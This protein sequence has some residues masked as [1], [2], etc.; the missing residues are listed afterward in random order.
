LIDARSR[1]R[2]AVKFCGVPAFPKPL[3][4]TTVILEPDRPVEHDHDQASFGSYGV[5]HDIRR[6]VAHPRRARGRGVPFRKIDGREGDDGPWLAVFEDGE[7]RRR[8]TPNRPPVL[9]EDRD[10]HLDDV[11]PRLKRSRK[12]RGGGLLL[13]P[14][15]GGQDRESEEANEHTRRSSHL[16]VSSGWRGDST[17][18]SG[19]RTCR[20]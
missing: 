15:V 20:D 5:G 8:Q 9:V 1:D 17:S 14:P 13:R 2:S 3:E 11:N 6:D 19:E 12:L 4:K 18:P 7:V 10:V 16:P